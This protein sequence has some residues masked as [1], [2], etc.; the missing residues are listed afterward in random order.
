MKNKISHFILILAIILFNF[1]C[2]N[3]LTLIEP[4]TTSIPIVYGYFDVN[5]STTY[6]RIEKAFVDPITS[7]LVLAKDTAS[8]LYRENELDVKLTNV[9]NNNAIVK[10]VRVDASKEGFPRDKGIFYDNA[11]YLYKT[12]KNDFSIRG[13]DVIRLTLTD[14]VKN[15]IISESEV[16]T[17]SPYSFT[18]ISAIKDSFLITYNSSIT[19]SFQSKNNLGADLDKKASSANLFMIIHYLETENGVT[20]QIDLPLEIKRN[21]KRT[22]T[23]GGAS[24]ASFSYPQPG[25]QFFDFLA[26]NVPVKPN[27]TRKMLN[28]DWKIEFQDEELEN[29]LNVIGANT[30]ITSSAP[31]PVYTNI[32]K[33]RGLLASK[34][35][36]EKKNI[37]F[38]LAT[39]DLLKDD[40]LTRNLNFR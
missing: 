1:S 5:D 15:T 37:K 6:L 30:G 13:N 34:S 19:I 8:L 9:T 21:L 20:K 39:L 12:T 16:T 11:N 38:F 33:G 25:N 14:K 24:T 31:I 4:L 27:V 7:A 35:T 36:L 3:E 26:A 10:M 2:S 17:I 23:S 18:N 32:K 22:S 40:K 28:Y 29:Y